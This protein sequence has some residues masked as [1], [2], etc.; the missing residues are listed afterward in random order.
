VVKADE[1]KLSAPNHSPLV[2]DR[3]HINFSV[4]SERLLSGNQKMIK[5]LESVKST[6]LLSETHNAGHK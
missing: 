3:G 6:K 4:L 5:I 2:Q 1:W